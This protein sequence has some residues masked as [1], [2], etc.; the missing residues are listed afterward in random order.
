MIRKLGMVLITVCLLGSFVPVLCAQEAGQTQVSEGSGGPAKDAG[1]IKESLPPDVK[2]W[3]AVAAGFAIAIAAFG[4]ALG[5]GKAI[6]AALEGTARNPGA[7]GKIFLPMI[8]GL[9]LIESLVLY[10]FVISFLLYTKL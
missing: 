2:K 10:T 9:A 1:A 8:I 5:Q 7:S 4:G 6:A 3:V